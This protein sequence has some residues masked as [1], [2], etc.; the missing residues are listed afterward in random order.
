[1]ATRSIIDQAMGVIM[2]QNRCSSDT[3]FGILRR[4]SQNRNLKLW[5]VA[6]D[7][8]TAVTGTPATPGPPVTK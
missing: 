8:I 1:M 4:A 3:A 6:G 2:A 5:H 7:I